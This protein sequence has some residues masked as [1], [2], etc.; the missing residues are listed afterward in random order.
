MAEEP[1]P[2]P[3]P[4][5]TGG[6]VKGEYTVQMDELRLAV[7]GILVSIGLTTGFSIGFGGGWSGAGWGTISGLGMVVL[8][9]VL[10]RWRRT[11]NRLAKRMD[12]LVRR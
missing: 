4:S 11:S 12:W 10:V 9:G 2:P 5:Y 8:F 7:L 6:S 1:K 3:R